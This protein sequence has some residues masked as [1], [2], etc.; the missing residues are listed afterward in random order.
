VDKAKA[1]FQPTLID[2]YGRLL[3]YQLL[4]TNREDLTTDGLVGKTFSSVVTSSNFT[5]HAVPFPIITS[6]GVN[7]FDGECTPMANGTQYEFVRSPPSFFDI[8]F[9]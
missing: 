9:D 8:I 1:G 3:S 2:V 5:N 4:S 6:R 7:T